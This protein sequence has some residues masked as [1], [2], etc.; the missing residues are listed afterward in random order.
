MYLLKISRQKL[1]FANGPFVVETQ[2]RY[3]SKPPK[4]DETLYVWAS[5]APVSKLIGRGRVIAAQGNSMIRIT[6]NITHSAY[7]ELTNDDIKSWALEDDAAKNELYR[8]FY[9]HA[10]DKVALLSA[11]AARI[12]EQYITRS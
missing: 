12:L 7:N 8:H 11:G 2:L 9:K 4:G 3:S 5:G 6:G 1:Q 10:H